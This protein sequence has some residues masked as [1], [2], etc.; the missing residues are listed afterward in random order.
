[1][2]LRTRAARDRHRRD[3][4]AGSSLAV[5]IGVVAVL[6]IISTTLLTVSVNGMGFT[7]ASRAAVE[8][9]AA[10]EG[11]IHHASANLAACDPAT[12]T[13]SSPT[14]SPR[15]SVAVEYRMEP[16]GENWLRDVCPPALA[17]GIRLRSTGYAS[18]R[19]AAG[20][21]RGDSRIM[22]A[23]LGPEFPFVLHGDRA[24]AVNGSIGIDASTAAAVDAN[25][26]MDCSFSTPFLGRLHVAGTGC[27]SV[28]GV[29]R[30]PAFDPTASPHAFP[31]LT[32][33][34]TRWPRTRTTGLS[35]GSCNV[36]KS[37]S[38]VT[39]VLLARGS[40]VC[41]DPLVL[42]NVVL[43]L[44]GDV[45][46]FAD[47]IDVVDLTVRAPS[48]KKHS[49]FLVKPWP[50]GRAACPDA[51]PRD[52]TVKK[53]RT[54]NLTRVMMY[55]ST[56]IALIPPTQVAY[57]GQIS[58]CRIYAQGN[59]KMTYAPAGPLMI[60]SVRDASP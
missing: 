55:S 14:D 43:E 4:E 41:T 11:G 31:R 53:V 35:A 20:H 40:F 9:Q 3:R 37:G 8:A 36:G 26:T 47:T 13:I 27:E 51:P 16:F 60:Q 2:L 15:F 44:T 28:S 34:D 42:T 33:T 21:T 30:P 29:L 23:V 12:R 24:I 10:A 38:T 58:A 50:A 1:M 48:G 52:V 57:S 6:G 49:L 5:V 45:V 18:S 54:E 17:T 56:E 25:G 39:T 19:G 59:T 22:E 46:V 32:A 7:S